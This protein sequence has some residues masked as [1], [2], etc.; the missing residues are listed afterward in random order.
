MSEVI[1]TWSNIDSNDCKSI[2]KTLNLP[3]SEASL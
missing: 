2:R 3:G 1:L